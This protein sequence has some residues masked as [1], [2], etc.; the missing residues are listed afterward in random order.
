MTADG[1]TLG[2]PRRDRVVLAVLAMRPGVVVDPE[3]LADALWADALPASWAKVVQGCVVRLRKVL[4]ASGV[5]TT[6]QGYRLRVSPD[7]VDSVRFERLLARGQELLTLGEPDRA[8]YVLG[9][10]LAL[11][12]GSAFIELQDW[13]AGRVEAGRLE[14]LRLDA[15][16]LQVEASLNVGRHRE[17][18]A[19][20]RAHVEAAPLRERRWALLALAQ[21]RCGQQAEALRTLRET[22]TMLSRELGLDPGPDLINL[23]HAIRRQDS[24]LVADAV[25]SA[26]RPTCPYRGLVP[27]DVVDADDYYGRDPEVAAT[28]SRL[29]STGAVAVVGPSG[30]GKSSLIRAGVSARLQRD[31]HR[32]VVIT[33]GA[34][35]LEALTA[36]PETGPRP[37]LVVDQCEEAVGLCT[38]PD[39]RAAFFTAL[40]D[41]AE[42]APLVA[43]VRAD[44]LGD[45]TG[46]TGF[47]RLVERSLYLLNPMTA[48]ALTDA[49]EGPA[50]GAGLRL[51]AG[52]ADLLVREVEGEPGA[53]PLLSHALR[54]TWERRE[55]N[56][57][58]VEGY[59]I[60]GGVRG[61]VAQSAEAVYAGVPADQ[62]PALRDLLLRMVA[63]NPE[64]DP[65]RSRLPRRLLASTPQREQLIETLVTAR[66]VTSDDGVV[67]LAHEALVRAWPRLQDWLDEDVEGQ[68]ILRHLV[69]AADTWDSM[70]RPDSEL[71]RGTRLATALEWADQS[72]PDLTVG[73]REFLDAGRRLA[74]LE[75]QTASQQARQ[76]RRINRRLRGLL[77]GVAFLT[78]IA[79]VAAAIAVSKGQQ[80]LDQRQEAVRQRNQTAA[81]A[82]A[83]A[84]RSVAV[85][86]GALAVA[87]AAES[88]RATSPPLLESI[89]A[90]AEARRRF[91]TNPVQPVRE[92][93]PGRIDDAWSLAFSADGHLL[94]AAGNDGIHLW[95]PATGAPVPA[96]PLKRTGSVTTVLFSPRGDV[97]ATAGDKGAQLWNAISGAQIGDPLPAGRVRP[98]AFSSTGGLLATGGQDGSVRVWRVA[99]GEIVGKPLRQPGPIGAI[100]FSPHRHVLAAADWTEVRLWNTATGQPRGR[101]MR[102]RDAV[103]SMAFSP[104]GSMLLTSGGES[105]AEIWSTATGKPLANPLHVRETQDVVY[106]MAVSPD[107]RM[108]ATGGPDRTVRLWRPKTWKPIGAPLQGHTGDVDALAFSSDRRLLASADSNG[109]VRLWDTASGARTHSVLRAHPFVASVAFSPDGRVLAS[110]D[111]DDVHGGAVRLWDPSTGR[112]VGDPIRFPYGASAV[113]MS[114]AGDLMAS[115]GEVGFGPVRLWDVATGAAVGD[116]IAT[117]SGAFA[118]AFSPDGKLLASGGFGHAVWLWNPYTGAV[119]ARF[120]GGASETVRALAFSP[121]GRALAAAGDT[122][123]AAG[124]LRLWDLGTGR[125]MSEPLHG[126]TRGVESVAFSPDGD[127]LAS[128]GLDGTVLRWNPTTGHPI[129]RPLTGHTGAVSSLAFSSDGRLLASASEDGTLRLWD[130]ASGEPVGGPLQGHS[131]SINSVA[132]GPK[133]TLLASGG[134]DGTIR[135]WDWDP[136][137]ACDLAASYV[138]RA[139]VQPYLPPGSRS[140]CRYAN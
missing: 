68:R 60:T 107:W 123:D 4:G 8:V 112:P 39:E 71:Y 100:A 126:H 93:L 59:R 52:L 15:E 138:T 17:A 117:R 45:L 9:D 37:V 92:P 2:L 47:T 95:N 61:A 134:D 21:Y 20:A 90:L 41:Y 64:G 88:V 140:V 11:W 67:E 35:P 96:P 135:L 73:E 132:F 44:R 62:R 75:E 18:L 27:F 38:D 58:T 7:A 121:D 69:V 106:G 6:P 82:L 26:P 43:A 81:L 55:G 84:S 94:A 22:R 104:D 14:E 115:I 33:P 66:L 91:D 120:R 118:I 133:S 63:P 70:G 87:L 40:T 109:V 78:V 105:S 129:G 16:E 83:A 54:A 125:P 79:L 86:N 23:E 19:T 31:G 139:Q 10:A 36:L 49:I 12:R 32:V 102:P 56:T 28:L 72:Q 42:G 25:M 5:E 13:H 131:S 99:T 48:Q 85:S 30:S 127:V 80:A 98:I 76:Q 97:L 34:H 108:M 114:P 113:A 50:R 57:L 110:A 3:R 24:S 116:P 29:T 65:M 1:A 51:E 128:G 77:T 136:S 74:A 89:G 130:P 124:I 119:V 101:P 46:H 137:R 122:G 103:E 53:L 111:G